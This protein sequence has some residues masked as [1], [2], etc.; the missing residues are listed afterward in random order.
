MPRKYTHEE[1]INKLKQNHKNIEALGQYIN[2][3]SKMS[4]RCLTCGNEWSATPHNIMNGY[5]G[6]PKCGRDSGNAKRSLSQDE[7]IDKMSINRP[8]LDVL[9]EYTRS[10]EKVKV[11]SNICGHVWESKAN[12]LL[13]GSGCPICYGLNKTTEKFISALN[14][15]NPAVIV[16]G[17]YKTSKSKILVECSVCGNKW[18]ASPNTLLKGC[19]CPTCNHKRGGLKIRKTHEQFVKE[20]ENINP[21]VEVIGEYI[22]NKS[23]IKLRCK[24][25]ENEWD[26]KPNSLISSRS[27]CPRCKSSH[28]EKAISKFLDLN[29]YKYIPQK[30]FNDCKYIGYLSF[31]FYIPDHNLC[32]EYDGA[33]HYKA[34]DYF[35][36]Q[37]HLDVVK[38]RDQI[39]T[40][41]CKERG[42]TLLRIQYWDF[43]NIESILS[44]A[45]KVA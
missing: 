23:L 10:F 19:G 1:F 8:D 4:F 43:D 37:D 21:D 32:I 38:I 27:G 11:R 36:G 6:C 31:D 41:Y 33:L 39:K 7:F 40:D 16:R 25:C 28:G 29:G 44:D 13:N 30:K 22:G 3:S 20:L 9:G 42:I 14:K 35:G 34:V 17:E 45:L 12:N 18:S 26:T 2:S 15:V 24:K 5:N